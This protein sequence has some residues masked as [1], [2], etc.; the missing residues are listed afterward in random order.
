MAGIK[1]VVNS[2]VAQLQTVAE[3]QTVRVFNNDFKMMEAGKTELFAFPCAFVQ[4]LSVSNFIPVGAGCESADLT[5]R[6]LI[7]HEY[8]NGYGFNQD[9]DVFDLK[10]KVV[11]A[12]YNFQATACSPFQRVNEEQSF[13]HDNIYIY[14]VDFS[15]S[16]IDSKASDYDPANGVY[17]DFT[18]TDVQI[19]YNNQINI[20]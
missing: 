10:D 6:I 1:D 16:F 17:Q 9:L 5:V 4:I 14:T 13:D 8:Y 18:A 12:M 11:R 7:G 19:I 2:I 20:Q 15:T 3:L